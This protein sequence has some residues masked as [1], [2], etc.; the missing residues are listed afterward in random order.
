MVAKDKISHF[1]HNIFGEAGTN[2]YRRQT[3]RNN[4]K[5]YIYVKTVYYYFPK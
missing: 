2:N 1:E 3:N 4:C 5:M